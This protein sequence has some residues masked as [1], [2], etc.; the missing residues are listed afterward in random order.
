MVQT[1]I[2]LHF[3]SVCDL[4]FTDAHTSNLFNLLVVLTSSGIWTIFG[5]FQIPKCEKCPITTWRD[6][7]NNVTAH[8]P[9]TWNVLGRDKLMNIFLNDF[10]F[11]A[12]RAFS[13]QPPSEQHATI[14]TPT[15]AITSLLH[16]KKVFSTSHI[17]INESMHHSWWYSRINLDLPFC[18]WPQSVFGVENPHTSFQRQPPK[19]FTRQSES[20][21]KTSATGFWTLRSTVNS[22]T[23]DNVA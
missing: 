5:W 1:G 9:M 13:A 19:G 16:V 20:L 10:S 12:I 11:E 8:A 14:C 17:I 22:E 23:L 21:W 6:C 3:A 18:F 15:E 7:L 4:N 2:F